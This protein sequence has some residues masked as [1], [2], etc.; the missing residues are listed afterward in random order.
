MNTKQTIIALVVA[1]LT[2]LAI[3]RFTLPSKVITKTEI[4]EV[5]KNT[6]QVRQ[7][8]NSVTTITE[9]KKPDGTVTTTTKIDN[10]IQTNSKNTSTDSKDSKTDKE[11]TYNTNRW[12][13]QAVAAFRPFSGSVPTVYGG[14]VSYRLLGPITV[15]GIGLSD[16]TVGASLGLSF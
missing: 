14:S 13:I 11:V 8:D 16:G 6:A 2:G 4:K 10:N 5:D 1:L 3:G 7:K 15:G 12:T 9:V